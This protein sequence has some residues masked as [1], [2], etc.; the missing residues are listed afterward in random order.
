MDLFTSG[1]AMIEYS[2]SIFPL[3]SYTC[4][5]PR[6]QAMFTIKHKVFPELVIRARI[7]FKQILEGVIDKG[8]K[9]SQA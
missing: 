9:D 2:F 4:S 5:S 7:Q 1:A 6:L 8:R 3:A